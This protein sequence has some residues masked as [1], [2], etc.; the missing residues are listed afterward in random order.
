[1]CD[2]ATGRLTGLAAVDTRV[3]VIARARAHR[4]PIGW[5]RRQAV[6][7][8][9]AVCATE[10]ILVDTAR[11]NSLRG[12]YSTIGL[13][14]VVLAVIIYETNYATTTELNAGGPVLAIVRQCV[15]QIL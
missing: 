10:S 7:P 13:C 1:M 2:P 14:R 15:V 5:Q 3:E 12:N 8:A 4:A 9:R 11:R 6:W